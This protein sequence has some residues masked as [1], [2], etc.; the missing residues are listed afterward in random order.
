MKTILVILKGEMNMKS[1]MAVNCV[2]GIGTTAIAAGLLA[3][4]IIEKLNENE[5]SKV[6]RIGN[7]VGVYAGC[8]A[9]GWAVGT[10]LAVNENQIQFAEI[11]KDILIDG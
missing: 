11:A 9:V 8:M 2:L 4:T 6:K 10:L 7:I 3:P 1:E 5:E